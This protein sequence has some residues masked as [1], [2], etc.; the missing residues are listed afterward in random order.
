[1][2]SEDLELRRL[3]E[4]G[5]LKQREIDLRKCENRVNNLINNLMDVTF[6][7]ALHPFNLDG[8]KIEDTAQELR[9]A[10]DEGKTIMR[11]IE[12]LKVAVGDQ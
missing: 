1:M 2:T 10:L 3:R 6:V 5:L 11:E 12:R 7:R 4:M 8:R 9:K